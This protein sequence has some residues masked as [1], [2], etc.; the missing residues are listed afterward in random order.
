MLTGF[1]GTMLVALGY[2]FMALR[3]EASPAFTV[4]SI[5]WIIHAVFSRDVWLLISNSI[6]FLLGLISV[7]RYFVK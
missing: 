1:L 6:T 7:I 2:L 4:A 5:I 3:K